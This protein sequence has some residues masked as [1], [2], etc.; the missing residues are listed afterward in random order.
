MTIIFIIKIEF[1]S[2]VENYEVRRKITKIVIHVIQPNSDDKD[3]CKK[4]RNK[5]ILKYQVCI[6]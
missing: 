1:L 2:K 4:P 6:I 5:P 3:P